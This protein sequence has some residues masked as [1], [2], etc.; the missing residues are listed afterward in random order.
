M[1][2]KK[3]NLLD[4]ELLIDEQGKIQTKPYNKAPETDSLC[5]DGSPSSSVE[6]ACE[7][8][9][10]SSHETAMHCPKCRKE[11]ERKCD[12][13]TVD[14][15]K[16]VFMKTFSYLNTTRPHM[17][18]CEKNNSHRNDNSNSTKADQG[19]PVEDNPDSSTLAQK[20]MVFMVEANFE[21]FGSKI[22]NTI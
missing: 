18:V 20:T 3:V 7:T 10:L 12:S 13:M 15:I 8:A 6:K 17:A 11:R 1:E 5:E 19:G 2:C 21:K 16:M 14:K 4:L 22:G 9:T